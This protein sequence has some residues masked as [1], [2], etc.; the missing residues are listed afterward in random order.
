MHIDTAVACGLLGPPV[1]AFLQTVVRRTPRRERVW[2]IRA[3]CEN[4]GDRVS[5]GARLSLSAYLMRRNSCSTCDRRLW[6]ALP[7]LE[8]VTAVV[9]AATGARFGWAWALPAYLITF[10]AFVAIVVVDIRHYL[11]PNRVIYPALFGSGIVFAAAAAI[12]RRPDALLHALTG[13]ICSWL[14]FVI[15]WLI[16]PRSMGFGDVRLSALVGLTTGWIGLGNVVIGLLLG[17]FSGAAV[18]LVIVLLRFMTRRDP[19]PYGPF[20]VLGGVISV[21]SGESIADWWLG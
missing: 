1:G 12:E 15:V 11:I 5:A 3:H 13:M 8:L 17:I 14:F 4:C 19:I 7:W 9:F 6:T 2:G 21:F 16:S 18:G 20:L 10:S